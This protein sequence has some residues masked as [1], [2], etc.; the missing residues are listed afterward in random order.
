MN[1][2]KIATV[3]GAI[4]IM[5]FSSL[6]DEEFFDFEEIKT[7]HGRTYEKIFVIS[8]DSHG[9]MFRHDIGIA[10]LSFSELPMNLRMLY[11]PAE[12]GAELKTEMPEEAVEVRGDPQSSPVYQTYLIRPVYQIYQTMPYFCRGPVQYWPNHWPRY[13]PAHALAHAPCRELGVRDFLYTTGLACKP[14]GVV[15]RRLSYKRSYW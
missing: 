13:H 2:I 12:S 1:F 15:T 11:E 6:A 5:G 8:A 4:S 14:P 7:T 3:M 10:K 9:L